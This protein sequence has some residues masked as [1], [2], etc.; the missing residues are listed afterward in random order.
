VRFL[1]QRG[2]RALRLAVRTCPEA[3]PEALPAEPRFTWNGVATGAAFAAGSWQAVI[4]PSDV[5]AGENQLG[6]ACRPW[7]PG[8]VD[9]G[10]DRREL[11]LMVDTITLTPMTEA[12]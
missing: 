1:L 2:E 10:R 5:R 6:I 12:P 9:G 3:R 8:A 7:R 11:G 4:R